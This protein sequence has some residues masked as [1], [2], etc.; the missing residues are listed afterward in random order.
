MSQSLNISLRSNVKE[1]S[2]RFADMATKQIKFATALALTELAKEVA[3][4]EKSN[5]GSTFKQP[6][7]F[8]K[9]AVGMRG[10]RK[11]NLTAVVFVKPIAARYLQ[12]YESGGN[13]VLPGRALLNPKGVKLNAN[14][15]LPRNVLARLKARPDVFIGEVKTKGGTV[16]GVWQRIPAAKTGAQVRRRQA[17]A[18]KTTAHLKLLIRFGDALPVNKRLNYRSRAQALVSRR[19]NPLLEAAI[20]KAKATAR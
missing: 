20:Q 9:N 2:K 12:P 14:G 8:T 17:A 4:D 7:T 11:D 18:T 5:I 19:F 16:N 1:V 3:A 15:Q 13:H 6:K 10:A